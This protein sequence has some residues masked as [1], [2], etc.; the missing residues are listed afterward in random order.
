M[1]YQ[2]T[3]PGDP[4]AQKRP[5]FSR[6]LGRAYDSQSDVKNTIMWHLASQWGTDAL[7][8][9]IELEVVYRV[10]LPESMS[11]KKRN[12]LNG[13]PC[14]KHT[15]IDNLIKM[16]LDCMLG[17]VIKDDS[18]VWKIQASKFWSTD[19]NTTIAIEYPDDS[20]QK[21]EDL[22]SAETC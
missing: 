3:I 21:S 11:V 6:R 12:R 2:L 5:R 4:I 14:L 15:D 22:H 7:E 17:I 9:P 10:K 20:S 13:E 8:T 19:P 18:Q 1:R 16:T